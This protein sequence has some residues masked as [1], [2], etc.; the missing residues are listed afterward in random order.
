MVRFEQCVDMRSTPIGQQLGEVRRSDGAITGE[1]CGA[2]LAGTPAR[3]ELREIGR[4]NHAVAV[5]VADD[6]SRRWK[7][8]VPRQT[9]SNLIS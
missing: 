6:R 5:E 2:A 3:Q 7:N 4:T 9:N 1:V 8:A